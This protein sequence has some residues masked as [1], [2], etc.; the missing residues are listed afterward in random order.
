MSSKNTEKQGQASPLGD[1]IPSKMA[2]EG[3]LSASHLRLL[4]RTGKIEGIKLGRDWY[5]TP[6]AV[7]DYLAQEN[8]PGPKAR[9][10]DE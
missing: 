1:L 10:Q 7:D 8:K 3:K 5:T 6:K 4:L 9:S 2:A